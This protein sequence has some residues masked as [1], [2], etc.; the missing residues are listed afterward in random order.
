LD[1]DASLGLVR[2]TEET[3]RSFLKAT[4]NLAHEAQVMAN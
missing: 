1:V 4:E 3:L 2:Y